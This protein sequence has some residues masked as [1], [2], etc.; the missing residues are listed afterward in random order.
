[1][2]KVIK[3]AMLN[4][5]YWTIN[6]QLNTEI[7]VWTGGSNVRISQATSPAHGCRCSIGVGRWTQSSS[8]TKRTHLDENNFLTNIFLFADDEQGQQRRT[9]SYGRLISHGD[10][11]CPGQTC[12]R[13]II[14]LLLTS[15]RAEHS[16]SI[17]HCMFIYPV[18]AL[19]ASDPEVC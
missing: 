1:M 5:E 11:Q 4:S 10:I 12:G 18:S 15:S 3:W 17:T 2:A 16:R 9:H 7:E 6:I 8:A 19:L 14:H 13:L